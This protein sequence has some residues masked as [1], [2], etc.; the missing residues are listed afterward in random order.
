MTVGVKQTTIR[1]RVLGCLLGLGL[2]AGVHPAIAGSTVVF[3]DTFGTANTSVND[4]L[5]LRQFG[6]AAPVNYIGSL[7]ANSIADE[8]L[9]RD[10]GGAT[11][12]DGNFASSLAD[13]DFTFKT[14][15]RMVNT[16]SEWA[17]VSMLSGV[18]NER[19]KSPMGFF[20]RGAPGGSGEL[21][22]VNY[23]TGSAASSA[24][25][26][27]TALTSAF[28]TF[29]TSHFHTYEMRV[30]ASSS[31]SGT[32][33][34]VVDG[35]IMLQNLAYQFSDATVRTI[36]WVNP[37]GG[38]A[39]FDNVTL[40]AS[41]PGPQFTV[42]YKT[43]LSSTAQMSRTDIIPLSAPVQINTEAGTETISEVSVTTQ[44]VSE[45]FRNQGSGLAVVGGLSL[46][47]FDSLEQVL[48][49][50]AVTTDG[51][52]PVHDVSFELAGATARAANGD[53]I[54]FTVGNDVAA[55][56]VPN[57]SSAPVEGDLVGTL[58]F[59]PDDT[60]TIT[61]GSV[62]TQSQITQVSTV[63][64]RLLTSPVSRTTDSL[65]NYLF[66]FG[67]NQGFNTLDTAQMAPGFDFDQDGLPN[68]FE[69]Y[70]GLDPTRND[71]AGFRPQPLVSGN[72]FAMHYL[73]PAA[74]PVGLTVSV[75]GTTD[76]QNSFVP[77]TAGVDYSEQ[78]AP[79]GDQIAVDLTSVQTGNQWFWRL[80]AR[81]TSSALRDVGVAYGTWNRPVLWGDYWGT[82]Q[83]GKYSADNLNIIRQHGRMLAEA[84]VDFVFIDWGNDID[85][86]PG[87]TTN[88]SDFD[89][90]ENTV[91][92]MF[93]EW[94]TIPDAPKISIMIG[95]PKKEEAVTDGRLQRKVDQVYSQFIANTNTVDRYYTYLGKPLLLI[96]T[97]TPCPYLSGLPPFSDSRF[98]I[99]YLTGFITDQPS[100]LGANLLSKYGYWSWEDRGPQ[101]YTLYDGAPEAC[102]ISAA[103]R[104]R[105]LPSDPNHIPAI[106]R[107]N[108]QTFIDRFQRA[109]D[110]GVKLALVV[111]WN[112]W[113]TGEQPSAEVSKDLEP[114][115]EYGTQYLDLLK[116]QIRL[117]K[118][119]GYGSP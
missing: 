84:D 8:M 39:L 114:S 73:R 90:I 37:S 98:T 41:S 12:L 16:G 64:F 46:H 59:S 35:V 95:F 38:E 93:E 31:S 28:G 86:I 103:S 110:L 26:L 104:T 116:D 79:S 30:T 1:I 74:T 14:Y 4:S 5:A 56:M 54:V 113:T 52:T 89:L 68:S 57:L 50:F 42:D 3:M 82:P 58:W 25:I 112:E 6:T 45:G 21:I 18:D 67:E 111:S 20:V 55:L 19:A 91:P 65:E 17:S 48:L 118:A 83:L 85:Y 108:G 9:L 63:R 15:M 27:G 44:A 51:G 80:A 102:T 23:G 119:T 62:T 117:F 69:F 100:L 43:L 34:F 72:S 101:T 94:K 78:T 47:W 106:G 76:L 22:V 96:Y 7:T 10:A 11:S 33:N 53:R 92:I 2:F 99:R 75:E 36:S 77:L 88:R 49:T 81:E 70:M 105:F 115:V 24:N 71:S 61:A 29:S 66:Q 13:N 40:T 87:V 60:L 109:R 97:G 32:F 107:K